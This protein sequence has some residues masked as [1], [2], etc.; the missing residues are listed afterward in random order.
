M[1]VNCIDKIDKKTYCAYVCIKSL[2]ES[3]FRR[4]ISA[5]WDY[6]LLFVY[7]CCCVSICAAE[8]LEL[9]KHLNKI[10]K[11]ALSCRVAECRVTS[12]LTV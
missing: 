9:R 12:N 8:L 11:D 5:W 2:E 4:A 10:R 7:S 6:R 1:N 3:M